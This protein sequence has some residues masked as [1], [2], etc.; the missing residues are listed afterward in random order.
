[1]KNILITGTSSGLGKY[2]SK[3]FK[4]TP[5]TR[6]SKNTKKI[7]NTKWDLII[8]CAF[9][10]KT[11]NIIDFEKYYEDNIVLSNFISSLSGKKIFISTCAIYDH[12]KN[13]IERK[14]TARI[15]IKEIKNTY[16]KAKY[17]CEK[18]F[19]I[20][21]NIIIRLGSVI[22]KEIRTGSTINTILNKKRSKIRLNESCKFSYVSYEEVYNFLSILLSKKK[23]GIYNFLRTDYLKLKDI[24]KKLNLSQI[25]YGDIKFNV[26]EAINYKSNKI[27]NLNNYTSSI[28]ILNKYKK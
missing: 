27:Y 17:I 9:N 25:E 15:N 1:M 10:P 2:L 6:K 21:K 22:G 20:D 16:A 3:K 8:H 5:F 12:I 18:F 23:T 28:D 14:E 26:T 7:V 24:Q 4:C 11:F 19:D 13:K